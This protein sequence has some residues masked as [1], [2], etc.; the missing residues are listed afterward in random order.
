MPIRVDEIVGIKYKIKSIIKHIA[1][2]FLSVFSSLLGE[3][4]HVTIP[5]YIFHVTLLDRIKTNFCFMNWYMMVC[6]S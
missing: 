2:N 5:P 3:E 4:T 6:L 1:H